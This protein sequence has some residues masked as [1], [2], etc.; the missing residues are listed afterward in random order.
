MYRFPPRRYPRVA[1][2]CTSR[3]CTALVVLDPWEIRT[4]VVG[5][6]PPALRRA[7]LRERPTVV[8]TAAVPGWLK[9]L[10]YG[11]RLV[12]EPVQPA[13]LG[14]FPELRRFVG[15]RFEPSLG[16]ALALADH[17]LSSPWP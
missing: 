11:V 3:G 14:D 8:A 7:L 13:S 15:T 1:A 4:A 12:E 10:P 2:L 6:R 17:A 9:R 5:A 16:R